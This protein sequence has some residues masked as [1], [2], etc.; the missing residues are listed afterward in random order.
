[1][2]TRDDEV[3]RALWGRHT[4]VSSGDPAGLERRGEGWC[5]QYLWSCMLVGV[6][7][8]LFRRPWDPR[9]AGGFFFV[10]FEQPAGFEQGS[11]RASV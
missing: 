8:T 9:G 11:S 4:D 1:M 3:P 2:F 7:K 6:E 5:R 10:G